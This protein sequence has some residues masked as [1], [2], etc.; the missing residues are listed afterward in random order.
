LK[1]AY[2][3]GHRNENEWKNIREKSKGGYEEMR[4]KQPLKGHS[5]GCLKEVT[6]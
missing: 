2:P 3:V 4:N 6:F 5:R 1:G